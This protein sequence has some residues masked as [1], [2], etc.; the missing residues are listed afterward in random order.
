M[1]LLNL[2]CS[3]IVAYLLCVVCFECECLDLVMQ[4]ALMFDLFW[5]LVALMCSWF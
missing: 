2:I 5:V 4:L 1:Q 3:L